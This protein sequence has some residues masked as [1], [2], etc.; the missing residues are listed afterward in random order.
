MLTIQLITNEADYLKVEAIQRQAWS[1]PD[2]EI[3]PASPLHA[4]AHSGACLL[5]AYDD[6]ELVG[7]TFG[8]LG[9]VGHSQDK[10]QIA[11][12]RLKMYSVMMG[13]LPKYQ[14]AGIGYQ[15]KLAQREF[16]LRLGIRLI[17]WTYDPL[18]SRNAWLN[19]GKLGCV[20][21]TYLRNFHGD[22]GGINAGLP[23]DRFE[24]YWWLTS[25][26]AR[27][28]TNNRLSKRGEVRPSRRPLDLS[29]ILGGGAVLVN[30]AHFSE[31]GLPIPPEDFIEA[32]QSIL[33]VEIPA[34]F[35]IIK[36]QQ[37]ALAQQWR[38]HSRVL[39][40]QLFRRGFLVTD[41]ARHQDSNQPFRTFYVLTHEN[42]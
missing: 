30:E 38:F 11:A 16:A 7:F 34:D 6:G 20:S 42:A 15:L 29:S 3:L 8:V 9:T 41:F 14:S 36:Q 32:D 31:Q 26:R 17:T 5:G 27:S 23:T 2:I 33:L 24:V 39:F 10:E 19:I 35:Q 1:M 37:P 13:V 25:N 4:M 28:R 12:A 22:M 40:E 21:N 18:E